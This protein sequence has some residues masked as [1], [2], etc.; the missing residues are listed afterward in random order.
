MARK[1][2]WAY[3]GPLD[4]AYPRRAFSLTQMG[5][6]IAWPSAGSIGCPSCSMR[7]KRVSASHGCETKL[8][9]S[10]IYNMIEWRGGGPGLRGGRCGH[11]IWPT[12]WQQSS[13]L[14]GLYVKQMLLIYPMPDNH[15]STRQLP[16]PVS[17]T[18]LALSESAS[19]N[20]NSWL[21]FG[22]CNFRIYGLAPFLAHSRHLLCW[23]SER[24]PYSIERPRSTKR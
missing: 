13:T 8:L 17:R 9:I 20:S 15:N 7:V 6:Q 10:F 5:E 22:L 21:T 4:G 14:K 1:L 18:P 2:P 24:A 3:T 12:R 16:A 19:I 23:P 11:T